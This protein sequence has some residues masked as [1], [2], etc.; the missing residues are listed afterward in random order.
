MAQPGT[1][2]SKGLKMY[3]KNKLNLPY[4]EPSQSV[5]ESDELVEISKEE[6]DKIVY[7]INTPPLTEE[8]RISQ[9]ESKCGEV[10]KARYTLEKQINITNLLTPYTEEDREDMKLFI[11]SKRAICYQAI[12]DGTIPEDVDWGV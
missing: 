10:I 12:A 3:Y 6:F 11:D 5:I 8:Q 2:L 1:N 9:I 7:E 4:F